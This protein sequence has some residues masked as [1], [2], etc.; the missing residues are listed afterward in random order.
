MNYF[1]T[2]LVALLLICPSTAWTQEKKAAPLTAEQLR[3]EEAYSIGVT[4]YVYGYPL[5]EMYRTRYQ[6]VYNPTVK[7]RT[8]INQFRH[9]K[10]L[11][12]PSHTAVVS[13]NNDTLYSSA[14]LDLKS[15]PIILHVPDTRGRYYVFQVMDFYTNNIAS[16]G[17]RTTSTKEGNFAFVGPGWKGTLPEGVQRLDSPTR[18]VWLLG[19]TLVD[20]PKDLPAVHALQK[21]YTLTP[22]RNWNKQKPDEP[23]VEK[24]APPPFDL[25]NPLNYFQMLNHALHENPPPARE[26]ALMSVFG[27]IGVGPDKVFRPKELDAAT[28]KGLER[29]IKVGEQMIAASQQLR[30]RSDGWYWPLGGIG[31][32]G[33]NYPLRAEVART[34]LASLSPEDAIYISGVADDRGELLDGQ[35]RYVLRFEKGQ[36]PPVEVFW[37]LTMYRLPQRLLVENPLKR[38]S[39]GDR[40]QGLRYNPDGSLELFI[41]HESPGKEKESNWLP[42]PPGEFNLI[43]RTYVPKKAL[44]DGTWKLPAIKR[45]D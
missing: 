21:Q 43:L 2:A 42:A 44:L 28:A 38:Y 34:A 23:S 7:E 24:D 13:P 15:E 40:T 22:L 6:R 33:D 3:E 16:I 29:A 31:K 8:P 18:A 37:S 30:T 12:D 27:R 17:K 11:L 25:S 39:I 4:A 9:V 10:Q 35:R 32:Y 14:W 41:Q 5:V 19:R 26:A 1:H 20:G 36:L 45:V